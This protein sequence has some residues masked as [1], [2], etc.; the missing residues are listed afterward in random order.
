MPPLN[1]SR[2]KCAHSEKKKV[3]AA[4]DQKTTVY[5][6]A[7]HPADI[8]GF[9]IIIAFRFSDIRGFQIFEVFRYLRFQIMMKVGLY[10]H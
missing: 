1:S 10:I 2:T 9:Q 6:Y 4:S 5:F 3:A 8:R 7:W